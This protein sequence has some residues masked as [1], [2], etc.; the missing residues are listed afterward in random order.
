ME[1]IDTA[2]VVARR[3]GISRDAQDRFSVESQRKVAEAQAA[4]RVHGT[5]S[6]PAPR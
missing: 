1:M 6:C 5:K 4:G 3:Y 2:D